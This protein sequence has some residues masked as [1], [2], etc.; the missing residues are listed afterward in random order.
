VHGSISDHT[1]WRSVLPALSARFTVHAMDR[2][3]RGQSGDADRYAIGR[4]AEDV[5]RLVDSIAGRVALLGHS[6]GALCSLEAALL[7]DRLETLVLYEPPLH[8]EG[9]PTPPGFVG[10]LDVALATG[11]RDGAVET[12]MREVVGLSPAELSALRGSSSWPALV[13]TV[14]TLPRELRAAERHRFDPRRFRRLALPAVLLAGEQSPEP[15]RVGG[16]R[17]AR[18]ALVNSRV[19]EMPGVGHE[20]VET[21]PEVFAA[22]VLGCLAHDPEVPVLTRRSPPAGR[23]RRSSSARRRSR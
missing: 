4:E 21:G 5:A 22:A 17:L 10:R 13:A 7:T 1:Y 2:R 15:L 23:P 6:Y 20:A 9:F 3:G 11:D 8:A 14:H 19:I 16:I 12:M 18:E